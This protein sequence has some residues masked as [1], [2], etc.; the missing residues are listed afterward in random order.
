MLRA[1]LVERAYDAALEEAPEILNGVGV[2]I[3]AN[4]LSYVFDHFMAV[5]RVDAFVS[6]EFISDDKLGFR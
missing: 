1:D 5:I 2:N 4:P 6:C 3:P